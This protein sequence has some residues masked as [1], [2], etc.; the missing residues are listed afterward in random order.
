MNNAESDAIKDERRSRAQMQRES[1]L[2]YE[3]KQRQRFSATQHIQD[4]LMELNT[5]SIP[6]SR[7]IEEYCRTREPAGRQIKF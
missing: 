4:A 6:S 3:A 5:A 2:R 7:D 1:R